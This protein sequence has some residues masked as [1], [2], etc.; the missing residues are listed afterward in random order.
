[1]PRHQDFQEIL[2]RFIKQYGSVKGKNLY[3]AWLK[4]KGY[5]EEKSLPQSKEKK[6]RQCSVIGY[7]LKEMEDSYHLLGLI[8]TSHV[9][10]VFDITPK[11]TL[12][13][14]AG[15]M[16]TNKESRIMGVH[17]SEG[18]TGEYY[19]E[20]DVENNP[21]KVI[22]LS[23]GE[24]GLLVDTKLDKDDPMTPEII[25]RVETGD[26]NSFS[27]T[28]DTNHFLSADFEKVGD[29]IVRV[30]SPDTKLYGYTS[31]NRPIN[32]NAVMTDFGFSETKEFKELINEDAYRVEKEVEKKMEK[33]IE[34]EKKEE[35]E[36]EVVKQPEKEVVTNCEQPSL[37]DKE[38]KEFEEYK[39][40]K[41][42]LEQ[43]E[44]LKK[45]E[46]S[47]MDG[48][49][50]KLEK[51]EKVLK[52][53]KV[54]TKEFSVE[55]KEFDEVFSD[56]K[57][58][59][60]IKE[61]FR[62]AATFADSKGIAWDSIT[63]TA[64]ESREFKNFGVNGTKLEYKGLGLYTNQ[65]TDSNYLQS[66]AELQ[67]VYDPVIYNALN[68]ETVFWNLLAKD[69]YSSKGNNMVQFKLKIGA[70]TTAAYYTG[71]SVSTGY[72]QRLKYQ[73]AFKKI[74]VGV[75]VDGDMLA[76]A[77]GGPVSD[78]FAQEVMDST[79]DMLKVVN[80][81]LFA[82]VGLE[83][84]AGVIGLEYITDSAGNPTLYN[85]TRTSANKLAP[86]SPTDTYINANGSVI[87]MALLR[88][89]KR[90]AIEE[91]ANRSNLIFVTSPVQA[92]L[93]RGKFDDARRMLT[94]KDT[95]FG[96][97]T[98]LFVDGIPVFDDSDC[99]DDDWFLVDR[100]T[101]RVAMWIPPTIERLGRGGDFVSAFIKMYFA[102][103]NRNPR[104]MVQIHGCSTS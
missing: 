15:Q 81:S 53:G 87:S 98:D 103:Y 42:E 69:D 67:D 41:K 104:R 35:P 55:F 2:N 31:A 27:I 57:K 8:A 73:T 78:V 84:A 19:G 32:P 54:D 99:N 90:Q 43:K 30:L 52:D 66:T 72:V 1:M 83:T 88:A 68:Q 74:Q 46:S 97:S 58:D 100:E 33:K 49:L 94:D 101:H 22:E 34:V 11:I 75:S 63:E 23:D 93:L 50:S 26:L 45:M 92:D 4:E 36:K 17:H 10:G 70:N 21:A 64:A 80:Q 16:N 77:N 91:G 89:A 25:K 85:L 60:E 40:N 96:F 38:L 18:K 65:N 3:Y 6:E 47:I 61:Q 48:V 9:D 62:R 28:Y 79:M 71:N 44:I 12:E 82:E 51:K 102:I 86:D 95:R 24:Y 59:I 39:K 14:F 20:A 7:E 13:S 56:S 37:E 76:A 29:K 5:S